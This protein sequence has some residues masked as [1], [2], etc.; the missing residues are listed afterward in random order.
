MNDPASPHADR[1]DTDRAAAHR[2]L[3][4]F[5]L[6][7]LVEGVGQI[8]GLIAQPLSF[9]LKEVHGWAALQVT[10]F[11]AVFNFPWIIKPVYG[12]LSD[13]VPIFG[14]RRKSYLVIANVVAMAAYLWS[15]QLSAPGE[16][17]W[18]L[19]LT[20]YAM[21]ISSKP[22][23]PIALRGSGRLDGPGVPLPVCM[24]QTE[25]LCA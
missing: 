19:Q 24:V 5:A 15:T 18:A 16:L 9:Y 25:F 14:Y 10:A 11:L 7:Y 20:A 3:W 23:P 21:A 1:K 4:F 22:P 8:G 2:L 12:L 6:V 17:V 13:F